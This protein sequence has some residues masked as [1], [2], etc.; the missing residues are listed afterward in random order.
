MQDTR[1]D[2]VEGLVA[3]VLGKRRDGDDPRR[4]RLVRSMVEAVAGIAS[5]RTDVVDLK[6]VSAAL[7]EIGDALGRFR[8]YAGVRKITAFGSARTRANEPAYKL[9]R[10]FSR[11]AAD[12][13]FMVITGAG[14][15]IMQ[16]CNEGAGRKRSFGVNIKLPFEN[17]ANEIIR[18]DNKLVE[19]KY[20]FTRK[21]F[22]L[23]EASGVVLFP[24]GFG[25]HDEGF[26]TLTLVQTGKAQLMPIVML[27]APG[28]GYWR[29]WDRYVRRHLLG[30]D[31]IS[32]DDLSLYRI[33][34]SP[35]E[36]IR[37]FRSFYRIFHSAR[38]IRRRLV[39][40]TTKQL[41][42]APLGHLSDRYADI[43]G[44]RPIRHRA[45]FKEEFDEPEVAELPRLVLDF[46]MMSYGRLRLLIDELNRLD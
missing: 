39:I 26:E 23:K 19:F 16:A 31:L 5:D 11:L 36:A 46:D 28:S 27:E 20:F 40:R 15:G 10:R 32:P 42:S 43:L 4:E 7:A 35:K 13:G 33:A 38:V 8:P 34:G 24:G 30:Q 17:E 3:N 12:S 6:L 22:F 29:A 45:A 9:A 41:G 21:L 2:A 1:K 14:P 25:T 44:G 37:E 18:G